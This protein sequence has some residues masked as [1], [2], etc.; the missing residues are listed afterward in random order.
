MNNIYCF[1]FSDNTKNEEGLPKP[2]RVLFP[3]EK[4]QLGWQSAWAA[5]AGM[6][7]VGNTCY[8]NSTLQALFHVPA[9]ANWLVSEV[10][11]AEKCNQQGKCYLVTTSN[12]TN[13]SNLYC[14]NHQYPL[15]TIFK[16]IA[17]TC[18]Q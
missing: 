10:A 5:G 11:H 15:K 6:Q 3:L 8:L 2:K 7:N 1:F 18:Y 12:S 14:Y 17:S 4:V 16:C 13:C 9:L